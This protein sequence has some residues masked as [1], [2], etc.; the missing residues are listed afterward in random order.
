MPNR[1]HLIAALVGT[2]MLVAC[3]NQTSNPIDPTSPNA[4][5]V[6]AAGAA[7]IKTLTVKG[8]ARIVR[9]TGDITD[10]VNQFRGLLGPPNPNMIQIERPCVATIRSL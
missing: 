1:R 3:D 8:D 7:D 10:A 6:D 5:D 9:A 2:V 4:A